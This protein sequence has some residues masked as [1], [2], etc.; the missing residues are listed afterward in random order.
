MVATADIRAA[1]PP[2]E[3]TMVVMHEFSGSGGSLTRVMMPGTTSEKCRETKVEIREDFPTPSATQRKGQEVSA[4]DV[5]IYVRMNNSGVPLKAKHYPPKGEYTKY[6]WKELKNST[7]YHTVATK[8]RGYL[9]KSVLACKSSA[10]TAC[11]HNKRLIH[12][13]SGDTCSSC[14]HLSE[15]SSKSCRFDT[16]K[17][18]FSSYPH[19]RRKSFERASSVA[20]E[21]IMMRF[22]SAQLKTEL[23]IAKHQNGDGCSTFLVFSSITGCSDSRSH[24]CR[25]GSAR[26]YPWQEVA[27]PQ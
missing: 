7:S 12:S 2:C 18:A 11:C 5:K 21:T 8:S 4:K 13:S 16:A 10:K 9:K 20:E 6:S 14:Y 3:S 25:I 24:D 19:I 17:Y 1:S 15:I 27:F 23:T 22:A 26:S